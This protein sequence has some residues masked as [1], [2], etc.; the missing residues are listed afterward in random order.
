[1]FHSRD[2]VDVFGFLGAVP[3]QSFEHFQSQRLQQRMAHLKIVVGMQICE[4]IVYAWIRCF[5]DTIHDF[6]LVYAD[7][8][9]RRYK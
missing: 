9:G 1:M 4:D 8:K 6:R 2:G 5:P 7:L 3:E